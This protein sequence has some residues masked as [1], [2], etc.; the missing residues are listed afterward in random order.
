MT[1]R[2]SGG[3]PLPASSQIVAALTNLTNSTTSA[4]LKITQ[5]GNTSASSSVG[6]AINLDNTN[7]TGAGVVLYSASGGSSR[8][9]SVRQNN[10]ATTGPAAYIETNGTSYGLKVSHS[11][12]TATANCILCE[13]TNPSDSSLGVTGF[14]SGRG[15][16]KVTHNKP[17]ASDAN[18]SCISCDIAGAGTAA[19]GLYID[20]SG[21]TTGK[22]IQLRNSNVEKFNVGPDGSVMLGT[23][24]STPA[25]NAAG[26]ILYVEGGVLKFKNPSGTVYTINVTPA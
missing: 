26:G 12:T 22:L 4:A 25:T 17:V 14:E 1:R 7:N 20:S 13:S 18:A 6:G 3:I 8:L 19:Q 2:G 11:G 9:F 21:G 15:T 10:V 23:V 24:S 5:S 16:I